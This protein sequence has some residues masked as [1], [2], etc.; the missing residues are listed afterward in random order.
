MKNRL[1]ALILVCLFFSGRIS[2][3]ETAV[4]APYRPDEFPPW[5]LDLRR[6]EVV[7]VG[8]FPFTFMIT[9]LVYDITYYA[10]DM[11]N[12]NNNPDQYSIASFGSHR[13]QDDIKTLLLIA[14]GASL[15]IGLT[16]F[17]INRIKR[18]KSEK[19]E[20]E[21]NEQRQNNSQS[22]GIGQTEN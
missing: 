20:Q 3:Q 15:T 19:R 12:Y 6:A 17:I 2:A 11:G 1:F 10:V 14:G 7:S 8:S 9:A 5:T 16:D 18:N 21:K 13:S 4:P 22:P